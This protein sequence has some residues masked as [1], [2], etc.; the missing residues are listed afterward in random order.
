MKFAIIGFGDFGKLLA[1][2]LPQNETILVVD[3]HKK[4]DTGQ[5]HYGVIEEAARADI[6]FLAVPFSSMAIVCQQLAAYVKSATIVVDVCSIKIRSTE[7]LSQY[8]SGICQFVST[9]P[10]FGPNSV[11]VA[12]D[13]VG[14]Q[15][16]WCSQNTPNTQP[17]RDVFE[18]HMGLHIIEMS[19][20]QHDKEMAWIHAL[21][22]FVGRT[23]GEM[24]IPSFQLSTGYFEEM[25]DLVQLDNL[26]SNDLFA[27]VEKYNPYASAMREL[28]I[29]QANA[30]HQ[31]IEQL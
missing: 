7:L 3:P 19:A 9:H 8:F 23:L 12:Q 30:V 27:T 17:L 26:Q 13:A 31:K 28:F 14:K 2:L 29:E 11:P 16:V 24:N 21:T 25:L 4:T 15:L 1:K 10:L 6:V 22:F 20:E 18:R 5:L